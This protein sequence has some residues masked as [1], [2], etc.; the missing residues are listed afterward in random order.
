M[1]DAALREKRAYLVQVAN[2]SSISLQEVLARLEQEGAVSAA[3]AAR[4]VLLG[5]AE[6]SEEESE[7]DTRFDMEGVSDEVLSRLCED[8]GPSPTI[9]P[10]VPMMPDTVLAG[11]DASALVRLQLR[12]R[13]DGMNTNRAGASPVI[14]QHDL[15]CAHVSPYILSPQGMC[16]LRRSNNAAFKLCATGS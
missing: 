2:S 13:E 12:Q 16:C 11:Y 3:E 10:Q 6:G 1:N 15:P 5:E 7:E 4:L 9:R 14:V 8:R